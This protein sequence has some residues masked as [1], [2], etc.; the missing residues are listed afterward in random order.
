MAPAH[1]LPVCTDKGAQSMPSQ[2]TH[3]LLDVFDKLAGGVHTGFRPVHAKGQMYSGT[4]VPA[5]DATKLTRTPHA[6]RPS[7]SITVRFSLSA[8]IPSVADNDPA[9]SAPQAI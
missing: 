5:P 7:T 9:G 1:G 6:A 4:F 3:D 8:G 2:L